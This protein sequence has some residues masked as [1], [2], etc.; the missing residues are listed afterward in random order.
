MPPYHPHAPPSVNAEPKRP[1]GLSN[2]VGPP[3]Y[4]PPPPESFEHVTDSGI[5]EVD[6]RSSGD[7]HLETTSTISTVSSISTLS[8]E[9]GEG[10]DTCTVYA[11]GQAFLVD[12]PPVP[13]KPK[14]KPIINKN[15]ALYRD[16]LIEESLESFGM[17]PMAPPPPPGGAAQTEPPKTPTQRSSK[18]WGDPPEQRSPPSSMPDPKANMISE[19]SSILQ[20][21][22][23][24]R[25]S[26]PGEALDSPTGSRC[27]GSR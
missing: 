19:L 8:S 7:P 11:D 9:G 20:H 25:T 18:L 1:V 24:D 15:N 16:P 22:N 4:P 12:R 3:S 2:C 5:E 6:S 13:P 23:R 27:F 21:I 17:P 14:L 10:L 26:K